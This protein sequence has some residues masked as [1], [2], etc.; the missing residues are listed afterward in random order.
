MV[1]NWLLWFEKCLFDLQLIMIS[2]YVN[3]KFD[4]ALFYDSSLDP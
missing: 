4:Y 2:F 3:K 1:I